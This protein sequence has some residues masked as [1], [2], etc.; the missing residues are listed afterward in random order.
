MK[1]KTIFAAMLC[2]VALFSGCGAKNGADGAQT[3]VDTVAESNVSAGT[4]AAAESDTSTPLADGIYTAEFTTDSSM[5]HVNEAHEGKGTLTV[6]N[7]EMT[8]HI[9]LGSKKILNLYPGLAK[10]AAKEDAGLLM[11]TEDTVTYSDGMTEE[12]YGFDV[13]VPYL[14]EEFDLALIGTKGKWY[15]HKVSVSAP[16]PLE[17]GAQIEDV[18]LQ[19]ERTGM[20]QDG[21]YS[22]D[23]TFE[24]GSGKAEILSPVTVTVADGKA[25]AIVEWSSPNYDYMI[26]DGEKYFPINTEGNS[27]FE[28]PVLVFDEPM[29]VIG[30]TVAMSKPH[31]IE[32]TLTFHTI[33]ENALIYERSMELQYAENFTVDYYEDGYTLLTTT[34]DGMQFFIVPEG[35]EALPDMDKAIKGSQSTGNKTVIL[36]RPVEDIYL[37]AS[38]VMDMFS[39][40]DGLDAIAFS[41]Q[42][43]DGWY[44]EAAAQAM[45][46]GRILYAGKYNKPDYELL[47]SGNCKLAIE[48]RM[49][50]H[51]P[52]V[53]EKMA[54]FDIP[55]MTDYSSYESH[56]LGRVEWVKFYGALL[57]K[58]EEAEKIFTKQ[59]EILERVS[60]EEKTDK[61]VAFF[62]ITANGLA[63][64]RQSSD[65]VP[66]MIELAGGNYIFKQ[67]GD[68]ETKRST[69]NMQIEEFYAGAKDADF[70]IY[71][72]SIDGGV[73]S[74]KELLDKCG[75]LTDFKAVKEGNV[76]CTTND[77]YQQSLSI[78]YLIE[79]M[80]EMLQGKKNKM[81]YLIPLK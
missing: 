24:G 68:S 62:F 4:G 11:P 40:L 58:E 32:Y 65:Y 78:G 42:K 28:I 41:G 29:V 15:D 55:V 17:A 1:K 52:E 3:V 47:V 81:H 51:A 54:D 57:G 35:K 72:S 37:V 6:K 7:G 25:T 16:V 23:I 70:L 31:E 79:D 75:L 34:M 9:S 22:M 19:K 63:Q 21:T 38:S 36:Q 50:S 77:M 18:Q 56:P 14:D 64:V 33:S 69:I 45:A 71:N 76:W 43:E 74:L 5:F 48:N 8:I 30:D 13:P 2:S 53:V 26:V 80:H 66:K 10:D 67:I 44:I 73:A 49:I 39:E 20:P 27:V 59:T 60:A 12:V 61:T 46:Q